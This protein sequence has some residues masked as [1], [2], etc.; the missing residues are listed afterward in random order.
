M[1]IRKKDCRIVWRAAA[2]TVRATNVQ[3][4]QRRRK[5]NREVG[6]K[7][8]GQERN[9]DEKLN[10]KERR[11]KIREGKRREKKGTEGT[12]REEKRREEKR[13]EQC[14]RRPWKARRAERRRTRVCS[15][16]R[17]HGTSAACPRPPE[18]WSLCAHPGCSAGCLAAYL[19]ASL[20]AL[21][22][23]TLLLSQRPSWLQEPVSSSDLV[24]ST[25]WVLRTHINTE[26]TVFG[27]I[28]DCSALG[29]PSE[30]TRR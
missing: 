7:P 27:D 17:M 11:E 6:E 5:G 10:R 22:F 2:A 1:S 21:F 20:T 30:S 24:Y 4:L 23:F 9:K 25:R 26:W 14:C 13:R 28:S 3:M 16:F 12:R 8:I 29:S 18:L 19:L 15:V